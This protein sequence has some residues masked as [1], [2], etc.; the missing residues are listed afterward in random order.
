MP[1]LLSKKGPLAPTQNKTMEAFPDTN[2]CYFKGKLAHI[3][4]TAIHLFEIIT[5][6]TLWARLKILSKRYFTNVFERPQM[7]HNTRKLY[8]MFSGG[9]SPFVM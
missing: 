7:D 1:N 8:L 2:C 9:N 3:P 5:L 4:L 6:Y